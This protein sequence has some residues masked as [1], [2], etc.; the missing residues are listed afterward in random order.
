[1]LP[2]APE[3][4]PYLAALAVLVAVAHLMLGPWALPS[5]LLLLG[6]GFLF[7]SLPREIPPRPLGVVSPVDAVVERVGECRDP[8]LDRDALC[9]TLRQGRGGE[10]NLHSPVEGRVQRYWRPAAHH[11]ME[12]GSRFGLWL[13]TDEQD[14][15]V[16][17]VNCRDW[18]HLMRCPVTT[19]DRLGQGRRCGFLGFGRVVELYLP[20]SARAEVAPGS[21]VLA[22]S[23]VLAT[24]VHKQPG[25][26]V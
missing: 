16:L 25:G 7:R 12:K 5:W 1:M 23:G 6:G 9:I 17:T 22:G 19:G 15:V 21:R 20:A 13:T 8:F 24:L 2:I 26:P 4:R 14:D 3:G 18:P 11:R 10:F